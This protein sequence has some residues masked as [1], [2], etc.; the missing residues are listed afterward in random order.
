[1]KK[2]KLIVAA[3]ALFLGTSAFAQT[4]TASEAAAGGYFLY[5]V[6][7]GK[8]FTG[9]NN[10]GT[11]ASLDDHGLYCTLALSN[12]AYTIAT[13]N[14]Q[15]FGT[16][17]YVDSSS[18]EWTFTAVDGLTN[19][20][21]INN[22]SFG[23]LVA[24]NGSTDLSASSTAPT[25]DYGYWKLASREALLA[26][27]DLENA[28]EANPIDLTFLL[29]GVNFVRNC[30]G[31]E[32]NP[33]EKT[34]SVTGGWTYEIGGNNFVLCGP[35][36]GSQNNTGCEMWNNT[37][38]LHQTATVPNGKYYVTC[39]GF[40]STN[41]RIYIN[42]TETAFTKTGSVN[43]DNFANAL[44]NI[45]NYTEGGKSAVATVAGKSITVGVKRSTNAGSEWTVVDNFRLY[46]VGALDLTEFVTAYE[47]ALANANTAAEATDPYESSL[48]A[49][50]TEAISTY[51]SVDKTNQDALVEATSAL[52]NATNAVNNSIAAYANTKAYLDKMGAVLENTNVYT[53]T[54]YDNYYGTWLAG[55]NAKT[56]ETAT[57][58]TLTESAAYSTGWHSSN[59]IDDILLSTWTIGGEQA[60]NYDKALY[61]NTW[62]TEGNT[63]GSEF[64]TPFFEYWTTDANSLGANTIQTKVTGLLPN[65]TYSLTIRAR[66]RQTN[67]QTKIDNGITMQVG[68]G[69]AVDI[70]AGAQFNSGVF[71]I[72]NFSAVGQTDAEGTLTGTITVAAN[73]NISWLSF[74]NV[75]YSEGEDLSAYIAD[76]EF[77][78][79]NVNTALTNDVAYASVQGDLQTAATTYATVDETDKAALIAAK[80]A[81]EAALAAYNDVVAPLKGNNITAWTTT[82]N[83]GSFVVNT[84]SVEGNSDGSG[85][86]TPFT[87]NWIAKGTNLTDATMSYTVEGLTPGYYKVT[88]LIRSLNEAG[89]ATPAGSFIF[90]NDA[91]ERA[92]NGT[93]CTNGVYDN[94]V[95]YGFVG[96]DGKLTIGVKIIGANVNW[97][98]WKNFVYTYESATLTSEIAANL[99][100]E[101]RTFQYNTIDAAAQDAAVTALSTLSDANYIA[102]GKAIEAAYKAPDAQETITITNA[103]FAT[104]V[105]DNTLDYSNVAGLTAYKAT[106]SGQT[107][108][109]TKVTT[110]PAGEGVLLKGDAGSYGVPVVSGVEAWADA[111]NAFVRGTGA[112][113]E[114]GDGPYNYILNVVDGVA[115]FYK[116]N[117]QTV[118]TNRAYLSSTADAARLNITFDETTGINSV[119]TVQNGSA[120][121]NL[122][123]QLVNG[124]QKGIF[125]KN[126][127]KVV[128]K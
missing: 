65:A 70:S 33:G 110:V 111:D 9:G 121:Y 99:T 35:Q 26:A 117:G 19:T 63:D 27:A 31:Y 112:A 68:D 56:L 123:G 105:S 24:T 42:D 22:G 60:N 81:L 14:G 82:G 108:T 8:Y 52:V 126:G 77:A 62:S 57:A 122:N 51:G 71:F 76:Y 127:K 30:D 92:Y 115:A 20:Y 119:N 75:K 53:Q 88:A 48:K 74:Y 124:A 6:G 64:L 101:A 46:Y 86:T 59:N 128:I 95:V 66:V 12:G 109:F 29:G 41:T 49:P 73:S 21:T 10:W 55:Y 100:E 32:N 83:N 114:T 118:A 7:S 11:H 43:S 79:A 125:I 3:C 106:V 96:E 67:N 113:V 78:L 116:A 40:G 28:S 89:G 34:G 120:V 17:G 25:D 84:W 18:A 87:Q 50:L 90:A 85:M 36:S 4:W 103:G 61:I 1:M 91:I 80:E 54:A 98:S 44:L 38:D 107:I 16:N 58:A 5:N 23:Y 37:F 94:P 45:A 13:G 39:D 104:Y 93:A 47:T 69:T 15:Y 102:A 72:G 97:V 2:L